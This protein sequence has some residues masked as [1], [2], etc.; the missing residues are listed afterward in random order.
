MSI[1]YKNGVSAATP[2][3]PVFRACI[4]GPIGDMVKR[5]LT[6]SLWKDPGNHVTRL[7][8]ENLHVNS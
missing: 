5:L 1:I 4:D 3:G 7:V 6:D 8:L 2:I